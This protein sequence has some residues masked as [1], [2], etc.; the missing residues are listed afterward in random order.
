[1]QQLHALCRLEATPWLCVLRE[2]RE[3]HGE[4]VPHVL[5]RN[6]SDCTYCFGCVGLSKKDFYVL[7]VPFTRQ[8]FFEVTKRLRK[9]LG[10]RVK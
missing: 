5:A 6:L 3:L 1:M 7:N 9:E 4:R 10:L 8:E 2:F